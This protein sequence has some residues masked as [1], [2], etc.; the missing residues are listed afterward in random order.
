MHVKGMD[1]SHLK[2]FG[3]KET[4]SPQDIASARALLIVCY[5]N[6]CAC[7]VKNQNWKRVIETA[8]EVF[9]Y[10]FIYLLISLFLYFFIY[11]LIISFFGK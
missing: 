11:V 3:V 4:S 6:L 8:N 2:A 10:L 1:V 7:H 5:N 9:I